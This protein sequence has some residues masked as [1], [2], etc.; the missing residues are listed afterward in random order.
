MHYVDKNEDSEEPVQERSLKMVAVKSETKKDL[1]E[2]I[3]KELG[4]LNIDL[5]NLVSEFLDG[6]ANISGKYERL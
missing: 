2:V 4:D 3:E 1:S 6:A 5:K